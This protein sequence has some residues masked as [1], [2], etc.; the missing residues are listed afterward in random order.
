MKHNKKRNTAFL[1]ESL[2][3]ELTK[4][5]VRQQEDRKQITIKIIKENFKAG[6]AL[7]RDLELYKSILENKDK[8]TKDFTD[9]FLVE[10]KKDY[11]AIDRKN[12]FNS[13]TKLISQINQQLGTGVFDNFIPNYKDIATVGTWFQD[14]D[15]N[16]KTRLIVETKVKSLLVPSQAEEKEMKHIDNLTYKTFVGK[17]NETYKNSLKENQKTLLTNYITS[18]SDNGLGLKVFV[19]EEVGNLKKKISQKLSE[20]VDTFGKEK[21]ENLQKVS[22]ILEDF[23]KK[24]LDEKLVKKLFYIQDLVEEL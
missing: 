7:K 20:G 1:Y 13:Q 4:A 2:V 3:K 21:H 11:N 6:S 19:N 17:F 15:S 22:V 18:F 16:A 12:V 8:M 14:N 23:N 10:T 5:V 24:P 9:R